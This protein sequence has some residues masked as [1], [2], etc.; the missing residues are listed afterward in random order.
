MLQEIYMRDPTDPYFVSTVLQHSDRIE[1][2]ISQIKMLLF[3]KKGE[4]LGDFDFG[5]N[6]EDMIFE[7]NIDQS[8]LEKRINEAVQKY[9]PAAKFFNT[10]IKTEFYQGTVRDVC[11]INIFIEGVKLYGVAIK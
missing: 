7:L 5:I 1:S 2:L 6:I 10:Q 4:V 3:T 8:N 11:F 9:C